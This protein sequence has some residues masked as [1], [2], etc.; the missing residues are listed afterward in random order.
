[1]HGHEFG[2][3]GEGPLDLDRMDHLGHAFHDVLPRKNGGAEGHQIGHRAPI[4]NSLH[5]VHGNQGDCFWVVNFEAAFAAAANNIYRNND[6][7]FFL[8]VRAE[9]HVTPLDV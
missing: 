7:E 5:H 8:L 9:N 4:A 6:E 2:P 3:V 1:M